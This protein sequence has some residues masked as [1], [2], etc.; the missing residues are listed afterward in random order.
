MPLII[1]ACHPDQG[2]QPA[3]RDL[4]FPRTV[5]DLTERV[6][7]LEQHRNVKEHCYY[8]YLLASRSHNFYVGITNDIARRMREHK[9]GTVDGF[10]STYNVNR[11]VWYQTFHYVREAI[12]REKQIKNWRREKKIYLVELS[13]PTWQDL[14][15]EWGKPITPLRAEPQVPPRGLKPLVG[16]TGLEKK[17]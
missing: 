12:A 6:F 16:M 2:L 17:P 13:N 7:Q 8:V 5:T 14:S 15:E 10:S 4:R 1:F 3:R 11:L 9:T